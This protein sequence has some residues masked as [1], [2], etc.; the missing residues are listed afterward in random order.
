MQATWNLHERSAEAAL[1][2]AC[3]A[4]MTVLVKEAVA[5]G[6]LSA[7]GGDPVLAG[8]APVDEDRPLGADLDRLVQLLE[9][10]WSAT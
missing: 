7:R 9:A 5:N 6:R 10:G 4:G 2:R 1:A 8:V 3:D